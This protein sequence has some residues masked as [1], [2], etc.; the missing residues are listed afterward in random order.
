VSDD[1]VR[2]RSAAEVSQA[3]DPPLAGISV[4]DLSA[5]LPGAFATQFL[6]DSGA[7]VILV[8]PPGGSPLRTLAGWPALA[9]GKR[10]VVLDLDDAAD[11]ATLDGLLA[12]ADVL[13]TTFAPAAS[14][15]LGLTAGRLAEV[16][17]RLVSAAITGWGSTGPWRDLKGYEGLVMAKLGYFHAKRQTTS[18]PGPGFISVPYA[19]WSAAHAALQGIMAALLEREQ[20]GRGQHVEA[21][22]VRGVATLDT[23][24]WFT[25]LVGQRWPDAYVTVASFDEQGRPAGQLIFPLLI[26]LTKDGHWLQFAQVE[27]RLFRAFLVELSLAPLLAEPKWKKFPELATELLEEFWELML[28]RVSER[29]L[30]EWEQVFATNP[31]ISAEL[32]RAGPA[33]LDHPQLIHD[34]RVV[35][36][37]DPDLGPVRQASTLV[38][39]G[40][41]PLTALRPAPRLDEHADA[42]REAARAAVRTPVTGEPA[43]A[44]LPLAGVTVLELGKMFAA[45]YGATLLGDLG[46]RVI[47]VESLDGDHIRRLS[48]FPEVSGAKVMQGKESVTVDIATEDGLRIVRELAR[49]SDVVLQSFRGGAA[50]RL[51]L[52][53]AALKAVHPDLVYLNAPGYGTDGPYAGRPAYAPSMGAAGGLVLTDVVSSPD[54]AWSLAE[55]KK[56]A[57]RLLAGSAVAEV[58]ADGVSALAVATGMLLGLLAARRGRPLSNM[59]TTMIA[60]ASHILTDWNVDYAG[61]PASP[62]VDPGGHGF[63]ALYRMYRAADGWVF[64]AAPGEHEWTDL[65]AALKAH[66]ALEADQRFASARE[67][68]GNDAALAD[69]L[70]SVFATG[71]KAEWETELTAAGIGCVAVAEHSPALTLMS[72]EWFAAGYSATAMS[73]IFDEHRRV[74][75]ATGFSRSATKADGGCMLGQHTDAVLR[76][77]G[78]DEAQIADL[79][80]RQVIG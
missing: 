47:K 12:G 66:V 25:D 35:H 69:V 52:D 71:R 18:R 29:T 16:N 65:A 59:T 6:A 58:Q 43:P 4:V 74:A 37:E 56:T 46:A 23:W 14:E 8:E 5:T 54:G 34:G 64:L 39:A 19:S 48:P 77:I 73:P 51:G 80:Q 32:F 55:V 63:S 26:A 60:S 57:V 7:D 72:D 45:P 30:A 17:P 20:S 62:A 27:S 75:P 44:G 67:R 78:Y 76:E 42:V 41:G 53:E 3:S 33:T 61:R 22:L 49:H 9:R 2:D 40:G 28:Q 50:E 36:V 79:R 1:E 24:Q 68:A 10:S 15:R 11:R 38:H 70:G 31:N 13:V 21:D